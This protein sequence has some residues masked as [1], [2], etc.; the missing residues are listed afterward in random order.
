MEA[1]VAP[2]YQVNW[3]PKGAK[4]PKTTGNKYSHLFKPLKG[5]VISP[6]TMGVGSGNADQLVWFY[7]K[8]LEGLPVNFTWGVYTGCGIWHREEGKSKARIHPFDEILIFVGLDPTNLNYLGAE[9]EIGEEHERHVFSEPTVVICPRGLPHTPVITRWVD[10]PFGC[11]VI[12]L[13]P[14]YTATWVD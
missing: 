5:K 4:P 7:G 11:F 12:S 1:T 8:D 9:I 14:Q 10:K 13:S 6:R 3:M 2:A